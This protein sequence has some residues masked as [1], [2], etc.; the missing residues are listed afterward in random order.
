MKHQNNRV[1]LVVKNFYK[2]E[3]TFNSNPESDTI[4]EVEIVTYGISMP[5]KKILITDE[6]QLKTSILN[7][8]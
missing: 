2:F 8:F 4:L 6:M 1:D 3:K 5:R 7:I